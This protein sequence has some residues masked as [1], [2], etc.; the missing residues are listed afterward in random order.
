MCL[1]D[2]SWHAC[3]YLLFASSASPEM[4]S[5]Y[6]RMSPGWQ[7][8][9]A[10]MAA[11]AEKR[12]AETRLFLILDVYKRQGP[13][14]MVATI[15]TGLARMVV[16]AL[17]AL[18]FS[19]MAALCKDLTVWLAAVSYTHLIPS[20]SASTIGSNAPVAMESS[21]SCTE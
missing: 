12:M 2:R 17:L 10:Q 9:A 14:N 8:N 6:S 1:R 11:R 3:D 15:S 4:P 5:T 21:T 18:A 16:Y 19:E 20:P 7:S 13:V